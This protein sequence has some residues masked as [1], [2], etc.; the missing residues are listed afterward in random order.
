MN[1]LVKYVLLI[2][3]FGNAQ[4]QQEGVQVGGATLFPTVGL[5]YGYSDNVF[6][7]SDEQNELSSNFTVFSPGIRLEAEGD[8]TDFLAQYDYNKT[9]F[10]G[11]SEYDF[12]MYHVL[13][14]LGYNA[15]S[16]SRV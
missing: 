12:E 14:S 8:K 10:N 7:T 5:S 3:L 16:R 4:A 11:A 6:F 1:K 15:S 9:S 13:A 2:L